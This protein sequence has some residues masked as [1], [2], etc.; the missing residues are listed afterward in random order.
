MTELE[1]CI[2]TKITISLDAINSDMSE[3]IKRFERLKSEV[4]ETRALREQ[5]NR[6]VCI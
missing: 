1:N 4:A 2:T 5:V 6:L 3:L